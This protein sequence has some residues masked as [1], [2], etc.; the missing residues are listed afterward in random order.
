MFWWFEVS[1]CIVCLPLAD[2][3][4]LCV[5]M[6][7]YACTCVYM[8]VCVCVPCVHMCMYACLGDEVFLGSLRHFLCAGLL[9]VQLYDKNRSDVKKIR[10]LRVLSRFLPYVCAWVKI[11]V[12]QGLTL[13]DLYFIRRTAPVSS[14]RCRE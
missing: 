8:S 3:L 13:T 4:F 5:R 10:S 1:V 9:V 7:F 6:F 14:V 11:K 2:V 12:C